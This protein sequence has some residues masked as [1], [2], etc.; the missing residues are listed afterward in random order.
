MCICVLIGGC[1]WR[2]GSIVGS[3]RNEVGKWRFWWRGLL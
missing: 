3:L 1:K 2:V